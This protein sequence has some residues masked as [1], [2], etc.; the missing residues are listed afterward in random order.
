MGRLVHREFRETGP[1]K[2]LE[3]FEFENDFV[4]SLR[5]IPMAVRFKL[6]LA[7]VKLSL[8]QW[9]RFTL[10]DRSQMLTSS[11]TS[12]AEIGL[13]RSRLIELIELRAGEA[14]KDIAPP[15]VAPWA[16][17]A[18]PPAALADHARSL[19]LPPP[20]ANSGAA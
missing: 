5:C 16:E 2:E 11:C 9:S 8:R 19:G 13:Y 15:D 18:D 20:P 7:G 4:A 17:G 6:D 3:L 12:S 10:A 14:A 1:N